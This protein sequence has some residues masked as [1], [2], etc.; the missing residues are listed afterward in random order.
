MLRQLASFAQL[1]DG[2][3]LS[4]TW[5]LYTPGKPLVRQCARALR[6]CSGHVVC[7][8]RGVDSGVGR[9]KAVNEA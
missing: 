1:A 8:G 3:F 2:D 5:L 9:G 6:R 7:S 4:F